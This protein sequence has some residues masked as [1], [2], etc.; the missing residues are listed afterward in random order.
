MAFLNE[1]FDASEFDPRLRWLNEPRVWRVDAA[2]SVLVLEPDAG[3]D[4]WRKTH[5]G[6][7]ADSGH[8]L[9]AVIAG[10]FVMTGKVRVK[11]V[12]QYDQAGLMVRVD[13]ICWIKASVEYEVDG[14]SKLGV[15]VTN[16]GYSDWSMQNFNPA[17]DE[18]RLRI[19]RKASDFIVQHS[20]DGVVWEQ[21]RVAHLS[22]DETVSM[23]CGLYACSPKGAGFRAEFDLLR[24]DRP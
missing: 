16:G 23:D 1:D 10:D 22:M 2:S 19:S 8:V 4:F 3:T 14:P 11:P 15:V 12:H 24:I 20:Q 7:E 5:Y 6:F 17:Y 9:S 18:L 21:L 13:G